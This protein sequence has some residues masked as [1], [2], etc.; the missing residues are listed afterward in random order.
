[1]K[2]K[3]LLLVMAGISTFSF[4]QITFNYSNIDNNQSTANAANSVTTAD[5]D[6]DG[7]I[8]VVGA[9]FQAD[10]FS[11]YVNDGTGS[12]TQQTI[13]NA[14]ATANGARSVTS[15]DLDEDG[16]MDVLA[17][18]STADVYV[19]YE[20]DGNGTFTTH[21]IDGSGLASEAYGIDAADFDQDGDL[22]IVG[23]ANSGNA[24][25][26][27][28]NDG[29]ENFSILIDLSGGAQ[30]DGVRAIEAF[31]LDMDGDMD[32]LVAANSGD[33]YSWFEN[34]GSGVFTN[35]IIDNTAVNTN[36]ASQIM[37]ADMDGDSDMDIVVGS[38]LADT[39]LWY[40]NDGS[41]NFTAQIIDQTIYSNG[42]RGIAL[43]DLE[44]DGDMD[45]FIAAITQDAFAWYEN[46]GMG[47]F[48]PALISNDPINANGA[49]AITT[50]DINGDMVADIVTDANIADAFS[51]FETEG[52]VLGNQENLAQQITLYPVPVSNILTL[53]LPSKL[54]VEGVSIY[55]GS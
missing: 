5:F 21:I 48:T 47:N 39:I 35:H 7:D 38:N 24:V 23:G 42:P 37:G 11:L 33:T 14:P 25:V 53:Q 34:N 8:D 31:D 50:A 18:A 12:F 49:F 28:A 13:D 27:Y 16:D 19:W 43:A 40:E 44:Q 26:V 41:Q 52:V 9:A 55:D 45:I 2:T 46:D 3:I 17:T 36:G 32:I 54:S 29:D 10:I 1:M 6:G 20:N 51:W 15:M 22:D 4:G 30:T